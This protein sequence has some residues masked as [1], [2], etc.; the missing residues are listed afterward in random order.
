MDGSDGL[1]RL[2]VVSSRTEVDTNALVTACRQLRH[3][4]RILDDVRLILENARDGSEMYARW[5]PEETARLMRRIDDLCMRV[6][7]TR[8]RIDALCDCVEY[9]AMVYVAAEGD[10]RRFEYAWRAFH[11][12]K[13]TLWTTGMGTLY[14]ANRLNAAKNRWGLTWIPNA[15]VDYVTNPVASTASGYRSI[16]ASSLECAT[17]RGDGLTGLRAQFDIEAFA[18]RIA[19]GAWSPSIDARTAQTRGTSV[20]A[21]LAAAWSLGLGALIYG[22]SGGVVVSTG[23]RGRAGRIIRQT[24]VAPTEKEKR[25]TRVTVMP[26]DRLGAFTVLSMFGKAGLERLPSG[27]QIG[28]QDAGKALGRLPT[29]TQPAR[30]PTPT[31]PSQLLGELSGLREGG[32]SGQIKILKHSTPT[33]TGGKRTSWSVVIRGTQSW[34]VGSSNPQDMLSNL[35]GVAHE[36]SEQCKAVRTAMTMAGIKAGEAVEI[37]GH[38][39]GGIIAAQLASDPQVVRNY[40]VTSVLTAGS[41]TGGFTTAPGVN[42]L[43]LENTRDIVPSLDG[44]SNQHGPGSMTVS[45]DGNELGLTGPNG[46]PRFA[47]DMSVYRTLMERIENQDG[48]NGSSSGPKELGE[49]Y[50]WQ[51]HRRQTL[52]LT[53]D[54]ET[55]AYVFDTRRMIPTDHEP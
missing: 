11:P 35:Q 36:D 2:V 38:S 34:S 28:T 17:G 31:R 21:E 13:G 44:V 8:V 47:H 42:M 24:A 25:S 39:Q 43:S 55:T 41:P 7:E 32:E 46:K 5:A 18:Q 15:V 3:Q 40:R 49:V 16:I 30:T 23:T 29:P 54:T 22:P 14:F 33:A 10:A 53:H 20:P 45:F 4:A 9:A 48:Q 37:V 19:D 27:A 52:G 12:G 51:E 6:E 50:E 26:G 1:T